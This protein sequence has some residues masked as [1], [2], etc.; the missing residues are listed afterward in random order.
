M[1]EIHIHRRR[2][3]PEYIEDHFVRV[4]FCDERDNAMKQRMATMEDSVKELLKDQKKSNWQLAMV[5]GAVVFI[6]TASGLIMEYIALMHQVK[7]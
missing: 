1:E 6:G 7:P 2:D 5:M 3:D 4:T